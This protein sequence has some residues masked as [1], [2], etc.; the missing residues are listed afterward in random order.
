MILRI[1]YKDIYGARHDLEWFCP[2]NFTVEQA[3]ECFKERYTTATF[4]AVLRIDE[5]CTFP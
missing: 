4:L 2:S 1:S 5:S 3:V